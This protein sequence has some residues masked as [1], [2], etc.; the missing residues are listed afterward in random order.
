MFNLGTI[1]VNSSV[2]IIENKGKK[3]ILSSP[4]DLQEIQT[5]HLPV[6]HVTC[7]IF[8]VFCICKCVVEHSFKHVMLNEF[9]N[10]CKI[11]MIFEVFQG[12][13]L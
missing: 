13:Y 3:T 10:Y 1:K 7:G 12:L 11:N 9:T 2:N 8:Q 6:V 5:I 4:H